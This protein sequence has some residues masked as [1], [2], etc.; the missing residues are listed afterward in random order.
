MH[1]WI[2]NFFLYFI[3]LLKACW[4]YPAKSEFNAFTQN[5]ATLHQYEVNNCDSFIKKKEWEQEKKEDNI[6]E[7]NSDIGKKNLFDIPQKQLCALSHTQI[8]SLS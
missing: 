3:Q 6:N 8:H 7:E 1:G 5:Q 2:L 4:Q